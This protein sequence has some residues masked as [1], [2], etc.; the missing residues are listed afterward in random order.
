MFRDSESRNIQDV[1]EVLGLT[2]SRALQ[3]RAS[4]HHVIDVEEFNYS[5]YGNHP[6][7]R[8][9]SLLK[10]CFREYSNARQ[11]PAL[12]ESAMARLDGGG[13]QREGL[14]VVKGRRGAVIGWADWDLGGIPNEPLSWVPLKLERSCFECP[15]GSERIDAFHVLYVRRAP[16]STSHLRLERV[17]MGV[18]IK[19]ADFKDL[20]KLYIELL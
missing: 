15:V 2:G 1:C 5:A 7:R 8:Y 9:K 10:L 11:V 16:L 12:R 14:S 4:V 13:L 3:L 20:P 19:T 6:S 18:I 17:G